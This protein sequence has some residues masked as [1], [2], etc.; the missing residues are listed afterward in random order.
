MSLIDGEGSRRGGLQQRVKVVILCSILGYRR[1]E[2]IA[3][4]FAGAIFF[5][6][7]VCRWGDFPWRDYLPTKQPRL[8]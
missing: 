1:E 7:G 4:V 2:G 6:W 8:N 3:Q 5:G